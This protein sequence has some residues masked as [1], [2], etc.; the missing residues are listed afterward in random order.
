[1]ST[2]SSHSPLNVLDSV[3]DRGLVP[4]DHHPPIGNGL[5][6][7]EWSFSPERSNSWPQYA[8]IPISW[9][10]LEMLFSNSC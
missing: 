8:Y 3:R 6:G 4:K 7:I 9:K 2:I 10:Q 1:M 5:W